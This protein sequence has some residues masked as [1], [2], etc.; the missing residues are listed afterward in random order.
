MN[1]P[2]KRELNHLGR[3]GA[4]VLL[5]FSLAAA[6]PAAGLKVI[7]HP[8]VPVSE[9]SA[10]TLKSIFLLTKT[11]LNGRRV[12]PVIDGASLRNFS[13][14][15]L[16]KTDQGLEIYYRSRV[17]A[18]TGSMPAR[19][20]SPADVVAHVARTPGAIGYVSEATPAAG[21]KTLRVR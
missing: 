9:I 19:F 12:E 17:F 14:E 6:G 3:S 2:F 13:F 20:I 10:A 15:Y 5:F 8:D 16:G 1:R 11:S 7:A 4:A 18:G 21:V